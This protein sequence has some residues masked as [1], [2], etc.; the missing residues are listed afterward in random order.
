MKNIN[1]KDIWQDKYFQNS[2]QDILKNSD[3]DLLNK[4]LS[5]EEGELRKKII[6]NLM[7]E[8]EKL[9]EKKLN[10]LKF[11]KDKIRYERNKALFGYQSQPKLLDGLSKLYFGLDQI[12]AEEEI[13]AW[14]DLSFLQLRLIEEDLGGYMKNESKYN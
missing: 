8:R 2:Y 5:D 14:K 13:K 6:Q 12:A 1:G 7:D 4:I 10:E 3:Q 11:Q 9:K